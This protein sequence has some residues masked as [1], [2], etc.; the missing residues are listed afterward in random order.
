MPQLCAA[1]SKQLS[2]GADSGVSLMEELQPDPLAQL[3]G[4]I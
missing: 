3:V 4:R 2:I 1:G